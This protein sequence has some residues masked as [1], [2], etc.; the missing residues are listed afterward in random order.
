VIGKTWLLADP[1]DVRAIPFNAK[2]EV[3]VGIET[4]RINR[5]FSHD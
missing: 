1:G 3:L 4:L 5:K 2:L